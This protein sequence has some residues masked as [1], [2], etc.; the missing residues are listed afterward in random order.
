GPPG[1]K[2]PP[3]GGPPGRKAPSQGGPPGRA[4]ATPIVASRKPVSEPAAPK[5]AGRRRVEVDAAPE[6]SNSDGPTR[7]RAK[8]NVDLSMFED[9]Q[10]ADRNAAVAWV[11]DE[12]GAGGVE[13]TVLMQLQSTGWSAEQSRAI[14]D[15]AAAARS[16]RD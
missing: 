8:V 12:L 10:T 9:S 7:R 13:R 11:V 1:R 3:G 14:L 5:K 6:E 4:E 16:G 2:G 15:L